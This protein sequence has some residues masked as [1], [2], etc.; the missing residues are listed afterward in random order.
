M[1]TP[2]H[3]CDKERFGSR[4]EGVLKPLLQHRGSGERHP[5][6]DFLF[7]YYS[8]RPAQLRCWSPG[9]LS[10]EDARAFPAKRISGLEWIVDYLRGMEM[11]TPLFSCFGMHEWAMVY[12][13]ERPRHDVPLRFDSNELARIVDAHPLK[14]THYDAFR[15]FTPAAQPKNRHALTSSNRGE[16]DQ[17][18]CIHANMDLYKWAYKYYPWISSELIL[19][20]FELAV[21]ARVLDMQASPYDLREWGFHPVYI[22][23]QEGKREYEIQQRDLAARGT[24]IRQQLLQSLEVLLENVRSVKVESMELEVVSSTS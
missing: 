14:C 12:R 1:S 23:T 13:S 10:R 22:E 5:V 19:D 6:Y 18:G 16:F 2:I 8:F 15:F 21:K 3:N 20:A 17:C 4:V 7:E 11:R 9:R 24:P